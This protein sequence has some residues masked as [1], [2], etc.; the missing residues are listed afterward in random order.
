[1]S[2]K[3]IIVCFDIND[4]NKKDSKENILELESPLRIFDEFQDIHLFFDSE[5]N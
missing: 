5:K 2:S 4:E 3:I 1:M